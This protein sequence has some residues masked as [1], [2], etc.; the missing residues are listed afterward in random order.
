MQIKVVKLDDVLQIINDCY[1]Q[2]GSEM[3]TR[4]KEYLEEQI[5]MCSIEC[6][7]ENI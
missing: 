3:T 5:E 7:Y 1:N 6:N 4:T 2:M